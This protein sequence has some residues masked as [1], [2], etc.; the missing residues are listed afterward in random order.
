QPGGLVFADGEEGLAVWAEHHPVDSGFLFEGRQARFP[1]PQVPNQDPPGIRL[2]PAA[3]RQR[4]T[5]GTEGHRAAPRAMG[6]RGADWF[7][8]ARAPELNGAGR[9]VRARNKMS[10]VPAESDGNDA[11]AVGQRLVQRSTG[12]CVPKPSCVVQTSGENDLA[13]GMISDAFDAG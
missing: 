3:G 9:V 1:A 4:G 2:T 12:L 8:P 13:A 10:A 11:V 5:G 7:A 6:Q